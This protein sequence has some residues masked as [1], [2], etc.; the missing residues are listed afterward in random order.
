MLCFIF[1]SQ[2]SS[3]SAFLLLKSELFLLVIT[4][5]SSPCQSC[6][7]LYFLNVTL[8]WTVKKPWEVS[9]VTFDFS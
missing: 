1:D 3:N 7:C 9:V 8:A 5:D 2:S 6:V 4:G